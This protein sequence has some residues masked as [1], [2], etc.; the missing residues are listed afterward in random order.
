MPA[1]D[2][3][4]PFTVSPKRVDFGSVSDGSA[5]T[6]TVTLTNRTGGE[7]RFEVVTNRRWLKMQ[8]GAQSG[9]TLPLILAVDAGRLPGRA[10]SATLRIKACGAVEEVVVKV[11]GV[12]DRTA[13]GAGSASSGPTAGSATGSGR[14]PEP[15]RSPRPTGGPGGAKSPTGP[16]REFRTRLPFS[17][18]VSLVL[19]VLFHAFLM[20]SIYAVATASSGGPGGVDPVAMAFAALVCVY[21]V[22]AF[23]R[24]LPIERSVKKDTTDA[25]QERL[26]RLLSD[27]CEKAGTNVPRVVLRADPKPNVTSHGVA[28]WL[29]CLHVNSGLIETLEQDDELAAALAHEVAHIKRMDTCFLSSVGPILWTIGGA[30][31]LVRGLIRAVGKIGRGIA[32]SPFP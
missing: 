18:S 31:R 2:A 7:F 20:S 22:A 30:V 5:P 17:I 10:D 14:R 23:W 13:G 24:V 4:R 1:S 8:F 29:G 28:T 11:A 27:V 16:T 26:F 12:A 25:R 9:N 19:T 3:S 21:Y 32:S 15:R 6:K